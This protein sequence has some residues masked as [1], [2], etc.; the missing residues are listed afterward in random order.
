MFLSDLAIKRPTV[1]VVT[2]LALVIF[3]VFAL[4]SLKVDEFP[5][6]AEPVIAVSIVYPGASPEG[7]ERELLD[8]IEEAI[9]GASG[10]D[11]MQS[12]AQDGFA[13]IIVFW[14]HDKDL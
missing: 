13:Q 4:W 7:V 11:K 1:T 10:I 12:T 9:S 5:D 8:P 14:N 6:V 3:G 2:M